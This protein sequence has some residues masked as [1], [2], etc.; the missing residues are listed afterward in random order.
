MS[1][2]DALYEPDAVEIGLMLYPSRRCPRCGLKLTW[3]ERLAWRLRR[4]RR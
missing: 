3:R 2:L 4:R 1:K